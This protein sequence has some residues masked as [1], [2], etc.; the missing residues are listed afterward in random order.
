L[1][2]RLAPIHLGYDAL[3]DKVSAGIAKAGDA[4]HLDIAALVFWKRVRAD[5]WTQA[6]LVTPDGAVRV[7]T[8]AAFARGLTDAQRKAAL[9]SLP[10]FRTGTFAIG[11]ALL[12]A[13]Q[14]DEYPVLDRRSVA[15]LRKMA[16]SCP[17]NL[18]SYTTYAPAVRAIRDELN[19]QGVPVPGPGAAIKR[20]NARDVD[21]ALFRA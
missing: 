15:T 18:G 12:C 8:R 16:P 19:R 9:A 20:W 21:K 1:L 4:G 13:W 2:R 3:L 6:F 14:Q 11:S 5:R 17:C 10:G 7:A